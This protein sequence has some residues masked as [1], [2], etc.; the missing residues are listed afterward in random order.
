MLT[1]EQRKEAVKKARA[2]LEMRQKDLVEVER[3]L[4]IGS[5]AGDALSRE[6]VAEDREMRAILLTAIDHIELVLRRR[7]DSDLRYYLVPPMEGVCE[8]LAV[9]SGRLAAAA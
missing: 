1:G 4:S 7:K 5:R 6:L 3:G 8:L 9:L 2:I